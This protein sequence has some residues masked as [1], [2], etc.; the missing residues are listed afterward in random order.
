MA[1]LVAAESLARLRPQLVGESDESQAVLNSALDYVDQ[2]KR[3][4]LIEHL[5]LEDRY[6]ELLAI[7]VSARNRS[8]Q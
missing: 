6:P 2:P 5:R 4:G 7:V 3:P 1:R 8:R